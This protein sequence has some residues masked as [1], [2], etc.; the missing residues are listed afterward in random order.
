[1]V[2][3]AI[4][5]ETKQVSVSKFLVQNR[6]P[7][8]MSQSGS[9]L[10]VAISG[11][12]YIYC[13]LTYKNNDVVLQDGPE[14]IVIIFDTELKENTVDIEYVLLASVTLSENVITKIENVCETVT[15]K[16]CNLKWDN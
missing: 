13:K 1:M 15:P 3:G 9:D 8:G 6:Y 16:P 2:T 11:T 7:Q 14:A 4:E 10:K 5:G 12:G